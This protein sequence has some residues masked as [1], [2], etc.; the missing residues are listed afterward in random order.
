MFDYTHKAQIRDLFNLSATELR[1][2]S[3]LSNKLDR[4]TQ[5]DLTYGTQIETE[6]IMSL[7]AIADLD[8][9]INNNDATGLIKSERID[10]EYSIT[11][12]DSGLVNKDA[13]LEARKKELMLKIARD[14]G[15]RMYG[16]MA[17]RVRG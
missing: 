7:S 9:Q 13:F 3:Y 1:S 17:S 8:E 15:Y 11:Y 12:Q 16:N 6:I 5:D 4:I 14:L 10:G 2:G